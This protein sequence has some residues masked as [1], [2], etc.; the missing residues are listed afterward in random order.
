[1]S[2]LCLKFYYK[3]SELPKQNIFSCSDAC[4]FKRDMDASIF[5]YMFSE[6]KCEQVQDGK[7]KWTENKDAGNQ[8]ASCSCDTGFQVC[9]DGNYQQ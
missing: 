3:N 4:K 2:I 7:G 1:M 9:P 5:I 8:S 6:V